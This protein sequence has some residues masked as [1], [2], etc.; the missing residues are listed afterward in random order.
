[1]NR[2][3][4]LKL[5]SFTVAALGARLAFPWAATAGGNGSVSF[6]GQ[7]YRAGGAGKILTSVDGGTTWGLH[8]DLGDMYSVTK[9]VV[10][11]GSRLRL[12]VGYATYTFA[13]ALAPGKKSWLTV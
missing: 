7:L 11:R 1:M 12:T 6:D 2:R 8:S 5:A 3:S 4:F 10:D 13:L 9:L